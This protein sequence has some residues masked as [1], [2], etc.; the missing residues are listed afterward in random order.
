[1]SITQLKHFSLVAQEGGFTPAAILSNVTQSALSNSIRG[2]EESLGFKLI[3]RSSRPVQL[4]PMGKSF[5]LR[6]ERLLFEARNLEM[7]AKNLLAGASGSVRVGMSAIPSASIG[8]Q[9][10][11]AWHEMFPRVH[12]EIVLESTKKLVSQL[13]EEEVD[14]IIGD[15]RDLPSIPNELEL[16]PLPSQRGSAFCRTGH[17]ILDIEDVKLADLLK[18]RLIGTHFPDEVRQ[19]LYTQ[20]GLHGADEPVIVVDCQ[21]IPTLR[22]IAS[23]SDLI[24]LTTIGCVYREIELGILKELPLNVRIHG[25][26][27]IARQ[28]GRVLHPAVPRMIE[29]ALRTA[30]EKSTHYQ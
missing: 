7:E 26:W 17:P 15:Q 19:A 27:S 20:L 24:L 9:I 8:G 28:R 5:L 29:A 3:E 21:S 25:K 6:V 12:I 13:L 4:T 16:S 2:L 23:T 18:Y 1:M 14:F 10:V 22:D 30:E 11:A